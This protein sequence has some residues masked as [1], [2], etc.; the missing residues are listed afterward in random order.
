MPNL[1]GIEKYTFLA[2]WALDRLIWFNGRAEKVFLED[3]AYAATGRVFHIAEN[4][5]ILKYKLSKFKTETIPPTV[6]KKFA[7]GRGNASKDDMLDAW[8]KEDNTFKLIQETGNPASDI[9]DAYFICKYG[10]EQ[11]S[12]DVDISSI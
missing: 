1:E 4:A 11:L 8:K 7:T 6:I 3:Y 10:Y 12:E 5:G 2:D 9:I